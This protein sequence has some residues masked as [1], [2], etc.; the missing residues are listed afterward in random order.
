VIDSFRGN[1]GFLSNFSLVDVE[2]DGRVYPS[3]E[4]A[5]QAAKTTDSIAREQIRRA[6]SP[7]QAK[8]MGR[9]LDLRPDWD[10]V[11]LGVM[12]ML[13]RQKFG[14]EPLKSKLAATY[15][16]ELVE[17]NHWNDT[18]WGVCD[19]KGENHLGRLLMKMRSDIIA[20]EVQEPAPVR[21]F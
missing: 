11:K 3:V 12:E 2:F 1:Y 5:Y 8:R 14:A 15:P 16:H 7:S 13:L 9:K 6:Y 21:W 17:G 10:S 4:H 18:Y 20:S 19:G